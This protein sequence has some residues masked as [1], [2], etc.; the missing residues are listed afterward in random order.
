[1]P[2]KIF[3]ITIIKKTFKLVFN[4]FQ[5]GRFLDLNWS[6][7]RSGSDWFSEMN[8]R[9]FSVLRRDNM[10]FFL[11]SFSSVHPIVRLIHEDMGINL[12]L[13][14][15]DKTF[16]KKNIRHALSTEIQSLKSGY[17]V[18]HY[19]RLFQLCQTT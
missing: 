11:I 17:K 13:E 9:G 3:F 14:A 2:R 19:A 7:R 8:K 16:S 18:F 10:F 4:H 12:I 6:I 1:V 5:P 15:T